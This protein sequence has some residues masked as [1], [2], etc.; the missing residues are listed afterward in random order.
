M[1]RAGWRKPVSDWRLSDLVS[2]GVLTRV[3]PPELVDEVIEASGRMQQRHRALPARVMA[4]FAIA[5]GLYSDG[6]YED[7]LT[8]LTDGLSWAS[9]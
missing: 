1:P 2:I 4:Y 6:S 8:Q 5:M 3:F 7:V 9:G